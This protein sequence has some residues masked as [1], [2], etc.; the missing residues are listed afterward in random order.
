MKVLRHL[1]CDVVFP[2]NQTCCGQP[3]YN[4]GYFDEA[5]LMAM[6]QVNALLNLK[7]PPPQGGNHDFD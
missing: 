6:H 3:A 2:E 4:S 7:T 5:R 1:G